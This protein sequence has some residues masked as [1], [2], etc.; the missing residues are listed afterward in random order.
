MYED[1]LALIILIFPAYIAN[2]TPVIFG[3]GASV[4]FKKNFSDG[5][6][7]FGDSKTWRGLFAG[8]IFG[9]L[10]GAIEDY[11]CT[12]GSIQSSLCTS[13]LKLGFLMAV[14]AMSGDL[15]GSFIKRRLGMPS[16]HPSIILD[17]LTFLFFA[18]LLISPFLPDNFLT[19]TGLV[20]LVVITYILHTSTNFIANRLGLKE[21]PW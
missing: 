4:D 1:F 11:L 16:G 13:Y 6:R 8:I 21:V 2:S 5:K 9:T 20:F 19:L 7:I 15:F 18:L 3:G 12:V 10:A 17:Q 14:G